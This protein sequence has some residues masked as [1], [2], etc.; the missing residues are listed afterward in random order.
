MASMAPSA[1]LP[2]EIS[3]STRINTS[4]GVIASRKAESLGCSKCVVACECPSS[5]VPV[6][7]TSGRLRR[8][9]C[10]YRDAEMRSATQCPRP[11]AVSAKPKT[12]ASRAAF[13]PISAMIAAP[14]SSA[15][16]RTMAGEVGMCLPS[17]VETSR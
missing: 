4:W 14:R 15:A 6:T 9:E 10:R 12:T 5:K 2:V 13:A 11:V 3:S 16:P 7:T 1:V 17:T 8:V